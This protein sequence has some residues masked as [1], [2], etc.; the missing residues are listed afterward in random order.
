MRRIAAPS[1][2]A[3]YGQRLATDPEV[4][5]PVYFLSTRVL[6]D[7]L[8]AGDL[9]GKRFLDM[10]TG[11]GPVAIFAASR[12]A[13]VTACDVN[14][15]A[16]AVARDNARRNG[17][18]VDVV[19]SNL[20]QA[21][22]GR[23]FDMIA[24]NIPFYPRE[25]RTPLEAAFFAGPDFETVRRFAADCGR[26]LAGDGTVVIVFSEDSG[27]ERI[28]AIFQ[29]A[30]WVVAGERVA[31]RLFEEFYVVRFARAAPSR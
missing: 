5:H 4:F 13:V 3:L 19:E 15:R 11:S 25:P 30:G 7:G 17:V 20:F 29:A 18:A 21:L 2:A 10:G 16:V 9:R 1:Q 23:A 26:F 6:L 27:R 14:P 28:L 22:A 31:R 8:A 24:F 12:G